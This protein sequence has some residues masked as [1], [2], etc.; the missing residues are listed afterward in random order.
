MGERRKK[1]KKSG[2]LSP[3]WV[4]KASYV[5]GNASGVHNPNTKKQRRRKDRAEERA[6]N[7]GEE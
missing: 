4:H 2:H 1:K 5:K 3:S 7:R 6:A